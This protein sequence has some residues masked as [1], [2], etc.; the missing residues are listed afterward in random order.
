MPRF[1]VKL[2]PT[3]RRQLSKLDEE[4]CR[5]FL[6]A[7]TDFAWG[8]DRWGQTGSRIEIV[9]GVGWVAHV[10]VNVDEGTVT[11]IDVRPVR[12]KKTA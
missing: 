4:S 3:I 6:Q 10:A 12:A 1:E 8:A 7:L 9:E 11:A 5:S 2:L